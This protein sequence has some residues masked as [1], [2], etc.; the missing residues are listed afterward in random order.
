MAAAVCGGR[1]SQPPGRHCL[2]RPPGWRLPSAVAEDR[3]WAFVIFGKAANTGGCRSRWPRIATS[4]TSGPASHWSCWRLPLAVAEDRN[5]TVGPACITPDTLAAAGYDGRRSQHRRRE[6]VRMGHTG[7]GHRTRWPR[8]A[9]G[10][11]CRKPSA[12]ARLAAAD[13]GDRGSQQPDHLDRPDCRRG[14]RPLTTTAEDRNGTHAG[15]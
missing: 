3:N 13:H 2:H 4:G 1:G 5:S 6:R 15:A 14:W 11:T 7:G 12:S 10:S 9:T 8:I